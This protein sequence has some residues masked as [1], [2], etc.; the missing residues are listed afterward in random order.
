MVDIKGE[1]VYRDVIPS[2][3]GNQFFYARILGSSHVGAV[4]GGS[5]RDVVTGIN[6]DERQKFSTYAWE[7]VSPTQVGNR[8]IWSRGNRSSY[9]FYDPTHGDIEP[10]EV[11][12]VQGADGGD[13]NIWVPGTTPDGPNT[14]LHSDVN[15]LNEYFQES[16]VTNDQGDRPDGKFRDRSLYREFIDENIDRINDIDYSSTESSNSESDD[17]GQPVA[18]GDDDPDTICF[19]C[20]DAPD[21]VLLDDI[22]FGGGDSTWWSDAFDPDNEVN[23]TIPG[24]TGSSEKILFGGSLAINIAE[25]NRYHNPASAVGTIVLMQEIGDSGSFKYYFNAPETR[26]SVLAKIIRAHP[27]GPTM[28]NVDDDED[29]EF[30]MW[31]YEWREVEFNLFPDLSKSVV[32][33]Q[34]TQ[35]DLARG[36]DPIERDQD[37]A[38]V[39]MDYPIRDSGDYR[40]GGRTLSEDPLIHVGGFTANSDIEHWVGSRLGTAGVTG[41]NQ[42]L[43]NVVEE[44]GL[45]KDVILDKLK[46][47]KDGTLSD[48]QKKNFIRNEIAVLNAGVFGTIGM[49]GDF[50]WDTGGPSGDTGGPSADI[51]VALPELSDATIA[52]I[53]G[54]LT[55]IDLPRTNPLA[56]NTCEFFNV[57]SDNQFVD[58]GLRGETGERLLVP[59]YVSPGVDMSR[60]PRFMRVQPIRP[61]TIIHMN[62]PSTSFYSERNMVYADGHQFSGVPIPLQNRPNNNPPMFTCTNAIDTLDDPCAYKQL[63]FPFKLENVN[64]QFISTI[65]PVQG[66]YI[67]NN[68]SVQPNP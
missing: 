6:L 40:V 21:G 63:P 36:L 33:N 12:T 22:D 30:R 10:G 61:G 7:E 52:G 27:I 38:V 18:G 66:S 64:E 31:A 45:F 4:W 50:L 65:Q 49:S 46:K 19:G 44:R 35:E 14:G 34:H 29:P 47:Y 54:Y 5:N 51:E 56:L 16:G 37:I 67:V 32:A 8:L 48:E 23:E 2:V 43:F 60:L 55:T 9:S 15:T 20:D 28:P 53:E 24:N 13:I 26:S 57:S 17:F 3:G 62:F 25:Y 68:D 41:F 1:M 59:R 11:D 42:P 58:V 39:G